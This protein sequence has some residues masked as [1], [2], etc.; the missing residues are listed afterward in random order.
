M[1]SGGVCLQALL[2]RKGKGQEIFALLIRVIVCVCA[3][4]QIFLHTGLEISGSKLVFS[5][6]IN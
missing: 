3:I 1:G 6:P 5:A 2:G 4:F